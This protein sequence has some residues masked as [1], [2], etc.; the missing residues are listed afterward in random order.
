MQYPE[1]RLIDWLNNLCS[2]PTLAVSLNLEIY[3]IQQWNYIRFYF[4]IS[5]DGYIPFIDNAMTKKT[6]EAQYAHSACVAHLTFYFEETLYR[7][8]HGCFL[9]Y[10]N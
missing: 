5:L 3:V 9:P 6:P 10:F 2:T 4:N 8:F 1:S 7:T